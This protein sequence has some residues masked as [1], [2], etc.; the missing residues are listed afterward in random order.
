LTVQESSVLSRTFSSIRQ[1]ALW[2]TVA[3]GPVAVCLAARTYDIVPYGAFIVVLSLTIPSVVI[4]AVVRSTIALRQGQWGAAIITVL[5]L[6]PVYYSLSLIAFGIYCSDRGYFLSNKA[7]FVK[8]V[9]ETWPSSNEGRLLV[10]KSDDL[11]SPL[12]GPIN[13][14]IVFDESGRIAGPTNE[15]AAAFR[16]RF[17]PTDEVA[18]YCVKFQR[19]RSLGEGFY[20]IRGVCEFPNT[21]PTAE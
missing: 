8:Q 16:G 10:L 19:V 11:G 5:V 2:W 17:F 6:G 4:C 7:A 18:D 3:W 21:V 1:A 14:A 9:N 13:R 12:T 15:D 20:V